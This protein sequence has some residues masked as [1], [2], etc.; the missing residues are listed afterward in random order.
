MLS[1]SKDY[2]I[3]EII[4]EWGNRIRN[5]ILGHSVFYNII[6]VEIKSLNEAIVPYDN[7]SIEIILET[8]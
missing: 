8:W 3:K 2:S 4:E 6:S 5:N 1:K 7:I